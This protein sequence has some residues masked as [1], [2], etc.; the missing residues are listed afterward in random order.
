MK[1]ITFTTELD[2]FEYDELEKDAQESA[3]D[4]IIR[5]DDYRYLESD[6]WDICKGLEL[7]VS[8]L[9]DCKVSAY[10]GYMQPCRIYRNWDYDW[11]DAS[12]LYQHG[13]SCTMN[14][15]R[16]QFS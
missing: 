12:L 2:L 6:S 10:P 14:H 1:H 16:L 7:V 5:N 15:K 9:P 13:T 11:I 3:R 4:F 8:A